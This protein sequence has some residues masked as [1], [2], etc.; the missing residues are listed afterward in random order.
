MKEVKERDKVVIS[1]PDS[2]FHGE[3]G[4]VV[5]II[6]GE[7]VSFYRVYIFSRKKIY[8][9]TQYDVKGED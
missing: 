3:E 5:G 6:P 4:R 1:N 9:F 8:T 7:V 2:S